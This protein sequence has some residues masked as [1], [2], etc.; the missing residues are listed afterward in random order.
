MLEREDIGRLVEHGELRPATGGVVR[1]IYQY[2]DGEVACLEG[3]DVTKFF[4]DVDSV[5]GFVGNTRFS[6]L[7]KKFL[8]VTWRVLNREEASALFQQDPPVNPWKK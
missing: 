7:P 6:M 8:D 4:A 3:K 5:I 2:E 1:I